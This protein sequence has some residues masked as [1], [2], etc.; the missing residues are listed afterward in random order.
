MDPPFLT[1]KDLSQ[2]GMWIRQPRA[3]TIESS[4]IIT[5]IIIIIIIIIM[6]NNQQEV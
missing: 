3:V 1:V 2:S 4:L 6:N 5:I